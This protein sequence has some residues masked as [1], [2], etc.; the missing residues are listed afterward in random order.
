[1]TGNFI[2][3]EGNMHGFLRSEDGQFTTVDPQGSTATCVSGIN[4]AGEIGGTYVDANAV[5]HAFLRTADGD[6]IT[7]N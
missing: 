6:I 3:A 7:L 5:Y 2:D 4:D 1:M